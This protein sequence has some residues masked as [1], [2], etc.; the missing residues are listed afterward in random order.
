MPTPL[1][2]N[3]LQ[4]RIALYEDD[5]AYRELYFRFF[6]PLLHFASSFVSSHETAEE[7]VSDV[8]IRVWQN[9]SHLTEIRNL[10]VYLYVC[11]KNN[12]IRSM[13]SQQR[14][15]A[16]SLEEV[17]VDL[18]SPAQ[19]PEALMITGE[20]IT[21]IETAVN[22]L[23]P[24]CKMVYKLIKEDRLKYKEVAQILDIS[25]KTIDN[26]LAIAL[27]KIAAAIQLDLRLPQTLTR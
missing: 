23:P 1:E 12:A 16:L 6:K 20:M 5:V 7:I 8:F 4:R 26:Q 3:D 17:G 27:K 11:T 19:D 2:L 24:K 18:R 9:R 14:Q 13:E 25:V 21:R 15:Q 22:G 10:R